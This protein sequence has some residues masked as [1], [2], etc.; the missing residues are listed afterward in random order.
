MNSIHGYIYVRNHT[1]YDVYD[2]CK[3]GKAS[4]IPERDGQYATGE[5]ERGYFEAV[6]QIPIKKMAIIER[7]LQYEFRQYN[8]KYNA[9]TEFY[10][11]LIIELIEPYLIQI[12]IEYKKLTSNEINDLLRPNRVKNTFKKIDIKSLIKILY[13][14]QGDKKFVWNERDYQRTIINYSE[15]VLLRENKIYIELPTGGGKSYIVYNLLK[16]LEC[17]FII[18]VSPRKIVNSQNIS[19]KYLQILRDNYITFNYSLENNINNFLKLNNKKIIICCTQSIN[20]LYEKI[21]S[22]MNFIEDITIWFDEAHWGIEDWIDNIESNI[23]TQFWLLN[24]EHIKYR[25]FTSASPDK[26]IV[27]DNERIFGE[28]YSPIKVKQLIDLNWLTMIKPLVYSEN[29]NNV[30]NIK[31]IISDF[32]ERK[33]KYGFSFHNKQKNAFNFFYKHYLKYKNGE[34]HIKPFLLISDNFIVGKD[35]LLKENIDINIDFYFDFGIELNYD[36]RD[37]KIYESMIYSIGYVVAKYSMGYDFNKLDFMYLSDPKLS[38]QDIKQSIGRGIRPDELG[39]NGSNKEKDL[40]V[41]LPVYINEDGDNKYDKIIEVLKYLL[42]DIEIPFEEIEFKNRYIDDN[43]KKIN[44]ADS[45]DNYDGINDVKSILL[46]LLELDKRKSS[47]SSVTYEKARKILSDK[48]I[49]SKKSYYEL[50][51]RDIRLPYEPDVIFKG[52]FKNWIEY[53]SIERVYYDLETCKNKICEYLLLYP[54]I[55]KHYFDLSFVSNELCKID[56]LFP[57]PSLWV[58]Y[59]DVCDLR[60]IIIINNKKKKTNIIL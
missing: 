29:I 50:C 52:Q 4:N 40:V 36:Y 46:D 5:I 20:K 27:F 55:K 3:L 15:N 37:I 24:R 38:I 59:Y 30:D 51:E 60:D 34:T 35:K 19:Q 28:L 13:S 18:I 8:V 25:I 33:R 11:K 48:N 39:E 16:R 58:E 32:N 45:N 47:L 41:S 31:Y 53:L 2:L 12:D 10:N 26:K 22:Q 54:E 44:Y 43:S 49:R 14:K 7:L 9:G 17:N 21:L 57:P 1:S 42:Y 6:F 56:S 23:N